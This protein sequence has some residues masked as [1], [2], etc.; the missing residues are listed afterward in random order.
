MLTLGGLRCRVTGGTDGAGA[1]NGPVVVLLHGFGAPGGDLVPLGQALPVP[2]GTRFIFPEAPLELPWGYDSRAW[3]LIDMEKLERAMRTGAARDLAGDVP[4]GLLSAREHVASLL[5]EIEGALA[6]PAE[7][8][9]I[10]GFSQGA[11][12]ACDVALR[13]A[14]PPAGL[15]LMSSTILAE[16]EWLPLLPARAGLPVFMSHG[17]SDPLLPFAAAER[18]RG[19]LQDAG[20]RVTWVPFRGA[21]EIPA[22]VLAALGRFLMDTLAEMSDASSP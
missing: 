2:E 20:A 21:H 12:L 13:S 10:G 19:L 6:A 22:A 9:I 14:R 15:V 8:V 4:P 17:T 7:R 18:L 3:W 5:L 11:M 16:D 1:G